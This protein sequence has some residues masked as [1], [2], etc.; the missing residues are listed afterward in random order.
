MITFVTGERSAAGYLTLPASGSGPGLLLLHAWWGLTPFF[1]SLCH[2][3]AEAGFVTLAPDLYHGATATTIAEA[4][5]LRSLVD[6]EAAH[7]EMRMAASYIQRHAPVRGRHL[8]TIGFSL[9]AHWALWLADQ[10]P[11]DIDAVVLFYGTSG[12]RFRKTQAAFLGHFA[13]EDRWGA[14]RE[15]VQALEE[16]LRAAG[17]DVTFHTYP[18]TEHWFAEEDRPDAYRPEAAQLAWERTIAWLQARSIEEFN[19]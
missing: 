17:R 11:R 4:K 1:I 12:G 16:R 9:G 7:Q 6:R 3:L 14:G 19:V 10:C 2:R 18:N 15:S 13:E 5:H 8:G